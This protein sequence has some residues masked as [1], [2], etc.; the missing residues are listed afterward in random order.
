M[1]E[2]Q[3]AEIQAVVQKLQAVVLK[4]QAVVQKLQAV[5]QKLQAVV[6]KPSKI[7]LT[8]CY[9]LGMTVMLLVRLKMLSF[10]CFITAYGIMSC[11]IADQTFKLQ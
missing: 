9:Q 11:A 5:V 1:H 4:I 8:T 7:M 2:I 3:V 10:T 6:Q